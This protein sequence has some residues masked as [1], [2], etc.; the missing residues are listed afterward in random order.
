MCIRFL[1]R[2]AHIYTEKGGQANVNQSSLPLSSL[3]SEYSPSSTALDLVRL[4]SI[5]VT[6]IHSSLSMPIPFSESQS[7]R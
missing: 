6:P 3:E 1:E 2:G 7:R 4:N 5:G